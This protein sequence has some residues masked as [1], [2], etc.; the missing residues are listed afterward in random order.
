[1]F[2][3][4]IAVLAVQ[5]ALLIYLAH[6][7][8]NEKQERDAISKENADLRKANADLHEELKRGNTTILRADSVLKAYGIK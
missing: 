2:K 3:F 1:M 7:L 8:G 4:G 6:V 5:M